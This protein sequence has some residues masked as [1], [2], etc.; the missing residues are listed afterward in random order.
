MLAAALLAAAA[1][2]PDHRAWQHGINL[3]ELG[4]RHLLIWSSWG[5]PPQPANV[6]GNWEHDIFY[7]WL[8]PARPQLEPQVLLSRPEAQEPPSAAVNRAGRLLVTWE[9]GEDRIN[10]NAGLWDASLRAL[11]PGIVRVRDGGHSGHVAALGD[12]FLIAYS[13]DWVR[14]GAFLDR[15]TGR[16]ILA[17]VVDAA[18]TLGPEIE[19]SADRA[20]A[21]REDWPLV[22]A[23]HRNWL[24]VWQRHPQRSLHGALID[25]SGRIVKRLLLGA[26]LTV[27]YHYDVQ[28]VPPLD[29]YVVLG[30]TDRSGFVSLVDTTGRITG[31]TSG[32]PRAV[33]ES[34][35]VIAGRGAAPA[36]AAYPMQP[37][38]V[39]LLRLTAG[40]ARLLR[41]I[42]HPYRWDYTGTVGMFVG[43]QRLLF[44]TLS[45]AGVQL[46]AIDTGAPASAR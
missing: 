29:R 41:T 4:G 32:L 45:R 7:S 10:Q 33:S 27:G 40:G 25:A 13:E 12:R 16:H 43:L 3:V 14:G 39:A 28:Y 30:V 15:G 26:E 20:A 8:D 44:A 19:I 22:A 34:R 31:I 24:V 18:G 1:D 23:S 11:P 5:H 35:L 36:L 38:G 46:L 9:D 37:S 2:A 6:R 17:R 42:E 21:H